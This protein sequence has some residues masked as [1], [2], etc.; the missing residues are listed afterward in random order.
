VDKLDFLHKLKGLRRL[1]VAGQGLFPRRSKTGQEIGCVQ[2]DRFRTFDPV[3]IHGLVHRRDQ[4]AGK[5]V[6]AAVAGAVGFG[7]RSQT[8]NGW[9]S[10]SRACSQLGKMAEAGIFFQPGRPFENSSSGLQAKA[11]IQNSGSS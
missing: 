8:G 6:L 10:R 11:C 9:Q 2:V 4:F 7:D 3:D 5:Q 1:E